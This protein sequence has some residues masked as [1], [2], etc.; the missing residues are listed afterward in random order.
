MYKRNWNQSSRHGGHLVSS[1]LPN[2]NVKHFKSVKI[3]S[4]FQNAKP[5][6][7]I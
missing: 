6:G 7:G 1:A 5:T 2:L 3:L 4:N